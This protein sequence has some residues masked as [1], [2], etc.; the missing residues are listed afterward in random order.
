MSQN[1]AVIVN[2][3]SA[4]TVRTPSRCF[5]EPENSC[6][7][8]GGQSSL[9]LAPQ[10]LRVDIGDLKLGPK[11][12]LY[13]LENVILAD[14]HIVDQGKSVFHEVWLGEDRDDGFCDGWD[15]RNV[16]LEVAVVEQESFLVDKV[17]AKDA[18]R[19]GCPRSQNKLV[20]V[21]MNLLTPVEENASTD[22]SIADFPLRREFLKTFFD[23]ELEFRDGG[24][25]RC[26]VPII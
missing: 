17:N 10:I 1:L 21:Y 7:I 3:P 14:E 5:D 8:P 12:F 9:G 6:G 4:R 23:S 26:N 22:G 18:N 15:V 24:A 20:R 19:Q 13:D 2:S 25:M 11:L 16:D